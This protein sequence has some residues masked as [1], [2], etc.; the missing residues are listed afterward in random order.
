MEWA[1]W[2]GPITEVWSHYQCLDY[3]LPLILLP[4]YF[5]MIN[6]F[7]KWACHELKAHLSRQKLGQSILPIHFLMCKTGHKDL[8]QFFKYFMLKTVGLQSVK[9]AQ[10]GSIFFPTSL[11]FQVL[12]LYFKHHI[13][14]CL[15]RFKVAN[16]ATSFKNFSCLAVR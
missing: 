6:L 9:L 5:L 3:Q 8:L 13:L 4:R 14:S 2:M 1:E 16:K 11:S 15:L 12:F 10:I 7:F